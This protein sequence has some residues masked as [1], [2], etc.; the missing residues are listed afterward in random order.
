MWWGQGTPALQ[1]WY[2]NGVG[3]SVQVVLQV[4]HSDKFAMSVV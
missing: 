3:Y 1:D 4:M 2:Q